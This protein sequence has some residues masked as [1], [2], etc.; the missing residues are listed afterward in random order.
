MVSGQL[1][2]RETIKTTLHKRSKHE[3][4]VEGFFQPRILE[5][6]LMSRERCK[7]V[8]RVTKSPLLLRLGW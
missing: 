7:I 2:I 5:I 4:G 8:L 3:L 6:G 1:P